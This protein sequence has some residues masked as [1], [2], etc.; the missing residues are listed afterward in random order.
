MENSILESI[1]HIKEITRKKASMDNIMIRIKKT[2]A[3]IMDNK[4]LTFE[5]E[6]MITKGLIDQNY[7]ILI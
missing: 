6:Q 7:K 2:S 3:T 5:I 4:P 1:R